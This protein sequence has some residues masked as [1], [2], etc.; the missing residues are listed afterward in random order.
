MSVPTL[1]PARRSVRSNLDHADDRLKG[2]RVIQGAQKGQRRIGLVQQQTPGRQ[3]RMVQWPSN[4]AFDLDG[5]WPNPQG[6]WN[7][8]APMELGLPRLEDD[9][10][11]KL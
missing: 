6:S 9:F 1:Q 11:H 10:R 8:G 2:E 5:L 4:R 3:T 7:P